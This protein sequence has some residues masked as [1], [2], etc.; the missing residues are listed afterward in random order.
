IAGRWWLPPI[1]LRPDAAASLGRIS[2][3]RVPLAVRFAEDAGDALG[4][5]GRM[6][7]RTWFADLDGAL[8]FEARVIGATGR[9]HAQAHG[10]AQHRRRS[11]GGG[12]ADPSSP[13]HAVVFG[14]VEITSEGPRFLGRDADGHARPEEIA[15]L[16]GALLA[17]VAGYLYGVP[18]GA[19]A[20]Y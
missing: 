3:T 2:S 12:C 11:R 6:A 13:W 16:L 5:A 7:A 14:V 19:L 18:L 20:P 17:G 1:R 15:R 8:P 4:G 10:R 9:S